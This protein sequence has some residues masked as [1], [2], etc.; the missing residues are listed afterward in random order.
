MGREQKSYERKLGFLYLA[1][2]VANGYPTY[3]PLYFRN[4]V[5]MAFDSIERGK[6]DES[7]VHP[8]F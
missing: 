4:S 1:H 5:D 7:G 6:P 8:G 3:K 2:G